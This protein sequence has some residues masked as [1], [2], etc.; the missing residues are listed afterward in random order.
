LLH[1]DFKVSNLHRADD[2][3]LLVLDWEFAF[4][5]PALCDIGQL[6]RWQP[7][8]LLEGAFAEAY[9][10]GGGVLGEGWRRAADTLDLANLIGLLARGHGD[11]LRVADLVERIRATV[12]RSPHDQT[13]ATT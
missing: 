5:G 11:A 6:L 13:K 12:G 10:A 4:A 9:R 8:A 1:G 2:G 7:S 3:A